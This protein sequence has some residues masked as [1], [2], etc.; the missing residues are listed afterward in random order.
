[1]EQEYKWSIAGQAAFDALTA[2]PSI[3][4]LVRGTA[5]L[6]MAAIYYDSPQQLI[7]KHRGGLRLRREND[8]SVCCLKLSP[9]VGNGG[10]Y[11]AREEYEC[12]APDIETGI[13]RLPQAGAPQALCDALLEEG[14]VELG[15]TRFSR[16]A[17]LL[18]DGACT[19]E[20]A[21][22]LGEL[23]RGKRTAPICEVE[24]ELKG[25]DDTAFHKLAHQ[26]ERTFQLAGQP[27][28]KLGRMLSL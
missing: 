18:D 21:F 2:D 27:L 4:P 17:V 23:G 22:D 1:M 16:Q 24:L 28:S 11:K 3:A 19:A 25:G 15:F 10:V 8:K 13:A 12:Q 6:D 9:A 14:L 7:K 5:R 20:L 26:L